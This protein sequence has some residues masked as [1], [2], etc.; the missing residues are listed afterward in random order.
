MPSS[1]SRLPYVKT[2]TGSSDPFEILIEVNFFTVLILRG[3]RIIGLFSLNAVDLAALGGWLS[4]SMNRYWRQYK[5]AIIR[6]IH[7]N[8][9]SL[10]IIQIKGSSIISPCKTSL[11]CH[12]HCFRVLLSYLRHSL[13][14]VYGCDWVAFTFR[15][16][17]SC[18]DL[19]Q[20]FEAFHRQLVLA[21]A[22]LFYRP[23]LFSL[24]IYLFFGCINL[25]SQHVRYCWLS[26]LLGRHVVNMSFC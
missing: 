7:T 11:N 20:S 8:L 23:H 10:V 2:W 19:E 1:P 25:M 24:V 6:S 15:K 16:S 3:G 13:K 18:F 17:L 4:I 22:S 26:A 14:P 21:T 9:C 5:I 12:L